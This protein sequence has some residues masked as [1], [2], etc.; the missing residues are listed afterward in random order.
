MKKNVQI[1]D[2][3]AYVLKKMGLSFAKIYRYEYDGIFE[4]TPGCRRAVEKAASIFTE[5]GHDV[6]PYRPKNLPHVS[7]VYGQ[8]RS[9]DGGKYGLKILEHEG[10]DKTALGLRLWQWRIPIWIQK[11]IV[12]PCLKWTV[13]PILASMLCPNESATK[14]WRLWELNQERLELLEV[15]KS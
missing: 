9:A 1:Y 13:S 12:A 4:A 2:C 10:L 11:W 8:F 3:S 5:L 14:S 7:K 6:R 15:K